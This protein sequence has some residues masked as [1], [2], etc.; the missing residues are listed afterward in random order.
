LRL[1]LSF[2]LLLFWSSASSQIKFPSDFKLI[3]G[4]RGSGAD[5]SYTNGKVT[6]ETDNPFVEHDF[7]KNVDSNKNFLS[8]SYRLPFKI[9]KDGLYQATG[10]VDGIYKYIIVVPPGIPII[11]SSKDKNAEFFN[12]STWLISTIRE[13]KKKG[14]NCS[15]PIN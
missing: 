7:V 12:Y 6:F 8:V 1:I 10:L 5:D 2:L 11:L 15:F 9:T 4:E 14:K 13:Y 3:K